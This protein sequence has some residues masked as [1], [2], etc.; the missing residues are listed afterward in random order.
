MDPSAHAARRWGPA[1]SLAGLAVL[2]SPAVAAPAFPPPAVRAWQTGVL[3]PDR[4]QHASLAFSIGLGTGIVT[5]S[6]ASGAGTAMALGIVKE[7]LDAR[8]DRWQAGDLAADAVG[9]ALA[10]LA[11]AALE[12]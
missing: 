6:P 10:A 12:R 9:A 4:L 1:L 11:T 7:A 8:R 2:A 3:A 5:R